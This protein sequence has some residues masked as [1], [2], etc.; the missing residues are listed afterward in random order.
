MS[1]ASICRICPR[2]ALAREKAVGLLQYF[3]VWVGQWLMQL[4]VLRPGL[5][6]MASPLRSPTARAR[7]SPAGRIQARRRS[8]PA[9]RAPAQPGIFRPAAPRA[10]RAAA[11][12][13]R[14][15]SK[16]R[17]CSSGVG[18]L[19]KPVRELDAVQVELESFRDLQAVVMIAKTR[20][21]RLAC[22]VVADE[23]R[24]RRPP[25]EGPTTVAIRRSSQVSRSL[26]AV[27]TGATPRAI[28][29]ASISPA[30]TVLQSRPQAASDGVAIA[31]P[32]GRWQ[33]PIGAHRGAQRAVDVLLHF[34][35]VE[36]DTVPL[37][38]REFRI[39]LPAGFTVPKHRADLV[40][41]ADARR[42]QPL[43]RIFGR[44]MQVQS[45]AARGPRRRSIRSAD[46]WGR[47]RTA[48]GSAPP[49]SVPR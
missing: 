23:D 28:R 17:R 44:G 25:S 9:V 40:A 31:D 46:R 47:M 22:G 10:D 3:R 12:A 38:H 20:E 16:R 27:A 1:A 13:R 42:K 26:S 29:T 14:S 49:G 6:K 45:I 34:P 8:S 41:V 15:W 36:A 43:H 2:I 11:C 30:S 48:G 35:D 7:P 32:A 5:P 33:V 19:V 18:Q 24:R 4:H 37:D 21:R 39:V